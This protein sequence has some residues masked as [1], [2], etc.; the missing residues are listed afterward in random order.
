M[1]KLTPVRI[2]SNLFF[3]FWVSTNS[4]EAA[5]SPTGA[6][7]VF[8]DPVIAAALSPADDGV[9]MPPLKDARSAEDSQEAGH[10]SPGC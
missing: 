8:E 1:S 9:G 2:S 4:C 3:H 10:C 7:L 6:P 5:L